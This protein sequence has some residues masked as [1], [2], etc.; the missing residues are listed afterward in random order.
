MT[1]GVNHLKVRVVIVT[2]PKHTPSKV[3]VIVN[4]FTKGKGLVAELPRSYTMDEHFN[5]MFIKDGEHY[6]L[7][8]LNLNEDE[9]VV[10]CDPVIEKQLV[11]AINTEFGDGKNFTIGKMAMPAIHN[12][13]HS[14]YK[15]YRR[16]E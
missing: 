15:A 9:I 6:A 16:I 3:D 10:G 2:N 7:N 13:M 4:I 8:T 1:G 11:D 14:C 12:P 5:D